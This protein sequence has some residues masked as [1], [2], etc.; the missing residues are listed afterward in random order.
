MICS[1]TSSLVFWEAVALRGKGLVQSPQETW[2]CCNLPQW[3]MELC[4][5]LPRPLILGAWR[6]RADP[7]PCPDPRKFL[8]I[9]EG[10]WGGSHGGSVELVRDRAGLSAVMCGTEVGVE[11]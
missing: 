6:G 11:G 7:S 1:C 9:G 4:S 5:V 8:A 2:S 3:G 10:I